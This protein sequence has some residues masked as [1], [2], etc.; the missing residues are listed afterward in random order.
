M[1]LISNLLSSEKASEIR[2]AFTSSTVVV[3]FSTIKPQHVTEEDE[4]II[5]CCLKS[6][7]P[8]NYPK[9][10]SFNANAW[11]CKETNF[12]FCKRKFQNPDQLPDC[13]SC[14]LRG[15]CR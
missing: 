6:Q 14:A 10:F 3:K 2:N 9:V 13:A 5:Q 8:I 7:Q 15:G 1:A 4:L 12:S 11:A